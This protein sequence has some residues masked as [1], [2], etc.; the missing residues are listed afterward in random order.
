MEQLN[1]ED[2]NYGE[3]HKPKADN[4]VLKEIGLCV[5]D[6][7]VKK[8]E[9]AD[10]K[11]KLKVAEGELS[12]LMDKRIPDL[13]RQC[14]LDMIKTPA[15]LY[16]ELEAKLW[17]N[18]PSPS[19][20]AK[21]R[22]PEKRSLMIERRQNA[23]RWL[24]ENEHTDLVKREFVVQF[25]KGDEE[26]ANRFRADLAKRK[27]PLH[28]V[29]GEDVNSQSLSALVR[30]MREAKMGFPEETLG[31]YEKFTVKISK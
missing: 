19:A 1:P 25:Q 15:G 23:I 22:D 10:L 4:E 14:G 5:E 31:V 29:E 9:V 8:A 12:D 24:E 2:Y 13:M 26:W 16:V 3:A 11:D 21:E 6:A 17:A 18:I 27:K 20:I 30:Q 7:N 28:V